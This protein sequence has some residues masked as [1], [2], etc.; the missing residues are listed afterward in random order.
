MAWKQISDDQWLADIGPMKLILERADNGEFSGRVECLQAQGGKLIDRRDF[1]GVVCKPV[2]CRSVKVGSPLH[3]A[4]QEVTDAAREWLAEISRKLEVHANEEG[5]Y[6]VFTA[7]QRKLIAKH[8]MPSEFA[9]ACYAA[10][11]SLV[12]MD[13]AAAA[14]E[15]YNREW[16]EAG[17]Q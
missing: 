16:A 6:E 10:V 3:F 9:Q 12:S 11:P 7:A 17:K 14:I 13:E 1:H 5:A 15:A 8:G 2:K 4:M